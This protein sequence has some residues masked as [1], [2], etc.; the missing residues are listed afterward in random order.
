MVQVFQKY[1]ASC[2]YQAI[3]GAKLPN[4]QAHQCA[5]AGPVWYTIYHCFPIRYES[6]KEKD[7][8][9]LSEVIVVACGSH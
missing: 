7:T 1:S 6:G 9:E 4:N 8:R 3:L 5:K 2:G